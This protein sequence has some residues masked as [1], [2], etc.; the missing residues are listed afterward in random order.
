MQLVKFEPRTIQMKKYHLLISFFLVLPTLLNAQTL[1]EKIGQMVMVGLPPSDANKDTLLVDIT[2]RNLGGVL[3]FAYNIDSPNQ[4]RGLNADLQSYAETPLFISIDQEGGIVARL[5]EQNGYAVTTSAYDL[6]VFNDEDSTRAQAARMAG[7]LE[8]AGFNVNFAPV[9]DLRIN[10]FGPA[11]ARLERSFS[12]SSDR[13]VDH[14]SWF[15]EEFQKKNIVTTIKH[16]PGHGSAESD[17]HN[18][19]TDITNQWQNSELEPYQRLIEGGFSDIVMTGHLFHRDWDNQYPASLSEYAITTML[20]D[21]LNFEGLVVTDELFMRAISDNYGFDEAILQTIKAGTDIL[22]FSTNVYN[23]Q[24]LTGYLINL[25]SEAVESGELS[26]ERINQSYQRIMEMKE[27]RIVTSD[28]EEL[29]TEAD[30]P[31]DFRIQNYPNPFNPSTRIRFELPSS[32]NVSM[33]VF[34]S[35]GQK[36]SDLISDQRMMAGIHEVTFNASQLPSGIYF[37]RLQ[38]DQQLNTHRITL[39]K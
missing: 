21:S 31:T 30:V 3:M 23:G 20:R 1:S 29:L 35:L 25:V 27:A 15:I 11:I 16:F 26:E 38:A 5:D 37:V 18:G 13:V 14:S 6:G 24:S 8:E 32:T 7:W 28:E 12:S 34:N 36:V 4:I 10:R 33:I 2:E 22:L 19:F 9:V 17:S 39:I